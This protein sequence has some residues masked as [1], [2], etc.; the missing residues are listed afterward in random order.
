MQKEVVDLQRE[1]AALKDIVRSQL[2]DEGRELL[3]ECNASEKLPPAVIEAC[4]E[5]GG[6]IDQ[7]D[8]N[9]VRSIQQSQHSFIITDPNLQ[10]NPIVFALNEFDRFAL[11]IFSTTK[12]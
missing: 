12:C 4:G 11:A 8:F 3:Q 10:D 7:Q 5:H 1:N 9:L 6:D 2:A